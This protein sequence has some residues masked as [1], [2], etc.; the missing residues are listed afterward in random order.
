MLTRVEIDGF[1]TFENLKVNLQPFVAIVGPNAT[2]KSNFFDALR[3][4]SRLAEFDVRTAMADLRGEPEELFRQTASGLSD[5]MKFAVE[6]LLEPEGVDSFGRKYEVKTRRLRYEIE[7]LLMRDGDGVPRR[8]TVDHESCWPILKKDEQ[9]IFIKSAKN[10]S[11]GDKRTAFIDTKEENF[12]DEEKIKAFLV[13]QDGPS[14]NKEKG[15]KRGRPMTLP[16]AEASRSAL[17]TIATAEFPHLYALRELLKS[18]RFLE[19]NPQAARKA[20][21]RFEKTT[22]KSDA[23]NLAAVLA[24][25]KERT[26]TPERPDGAVNDIS[27]DLASLIP[28]VQAVE[29]FNDVNAKE[30]SFGVKTTEKLQFSARVISD[31]T[32]RLLA[33]LTVLNDPEHRGV[34]CFEEPENGV[35]EGRI[36][37]LI[38]FLREAAARGEDLANGPLFQILVNTHSPAVMAALEDNEIIAAD[39]VRTI[40]PETGKK[41]VRTRMRTGLMTN[42]L[43]LDPETDL[44]RQ[45]LASFLRREVGAA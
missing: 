25:L 29:V 31:G 10:I 26:A 15:P 4:L 8:I 38:G 2:G 9:C 43:L 14:N 35:H 5:R 3:F 44:N 20:S 39:A 16:A 18:V 40:N 23:S 11:Y 7:L 1:K 6:V 30:Y 21:D 37:A 32:L 28:S 17:S 41:A 19:I 45:E 24:N 27:L 22:L 33:L 34:L 36:P 42:K 13:G 12:N